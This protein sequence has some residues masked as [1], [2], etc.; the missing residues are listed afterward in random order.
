MIL[1][2]S[3]EKQFLNPYL[4]R[5]SSTILSPSSSKDES[6]TSSGENLNQTPSQIGHQIEMTNSAHYDTLCREG[7]V[8]VDIYRKRKES[9]YDYGHGK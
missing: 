6:N 2:S 1:F 8:S 5:D 7:Y 9:L 4:L 3:K